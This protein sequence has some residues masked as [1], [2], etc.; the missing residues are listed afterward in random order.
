[1]KIEWIERLRDTRRF[2]SLGQLM[3]QLAEDR[4]RAAAVIVEAQAR[5]DSAV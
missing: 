2:D 1:V 4:V 5:S 3:A